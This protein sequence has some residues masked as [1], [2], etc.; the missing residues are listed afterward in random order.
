MNPYE[1]YQIVDAVARKLQEEMNTRGINHFFA[2]HGIDHRGVTTVPSKRLY[3]EDLLASVPD[4]VVFRVAADLGIDTPDAHPVSA[5]HLQ[6]YFH[7]DGL[8]ACREDFQRTLTNIEADP[9]QALANACATLESICKALL[10]KFGK[11]YPSDQS[12]QTL[13]RTVLPH[14]NLSPEQH[15]DGEIKR[16]LGGLTNAAAG[17]AVLRT[18]YSA[19]HGKG[20][21]QHRLSPR[22]VRLAANACC[23]VGLFLLET[24]RERFAS[25]A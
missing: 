13:L 10:D 4:L 1:R 8:T 5:E 25:A 3:V 24:Y 6:S 15:S 11:P 23:A 20:G 19:A 17:I 21:K 18:G 22:H 2:S 9:D 14:M 16:V 12:L 7:V